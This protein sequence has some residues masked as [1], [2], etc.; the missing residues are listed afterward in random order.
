MQG[1]VSIPYGDAN[2]PNKSKPKKKRLLQ[3]NNK[4]IGYK[5]K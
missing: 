5:E 2:F 3:S 1:W 4:D